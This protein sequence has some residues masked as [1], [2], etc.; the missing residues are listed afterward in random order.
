MKTLWVVGGGHESVYG[1]QRAKA[2]G[3][4]VIVSDGDPTC[5]GVAFADRLVVMS[6]YDAIGTA[7]TARWSIGRVGE[8]AKPPAGVLSFAS[9]V[10]LTVATVADRCGLIG[11]PLPVAQ[12][13]A[14]KWLQ[15][16]A[17]QDAGIPTTTGIVVRSASELRAAKR[18]MWSASGLFVV[19]PVDSRGAR[20]VILLLP[21]VD[22][23]WAWDQAVRYS[24]SGLVLLEEWADG[25]QIST[26]TVLLADGRA[27][28]PGFL[29]RNYDRLQQF[30]PYVIEDGA[31]QPSRLTPMRRKRVI[32]VA[33]AAAKALGFVGIAKGDLVLTADGP[34]VIEMAAR[35]SGG[36]MS[37]V[38]VPAA[39]GVQ[40]VDIAIKLALGEPVTEADVTP[41]KAKACAMRFFFPDPG[42]VVA[43]AQMAA[44][45]TIVAS[46]IPDIGQTIGL[47][48]DHTKRPGYVVA[49]ADSRDGAIR[50][51]E[52]AIRIAAVRTAV[53]PL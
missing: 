12:L 40:L 45:S 20:G 39:T 52:Q 47:I 22:V 31:T 4:R 19:K 44:G 21:D 46:R 17:L 34:R 24:Q 35:L 42:T 11:L 7:A 48:T 16:Q 43:A 10:P 18:A 41:T 14:D 32:E 3:L 15:K 25:P 36:L 49:V 13:A 38:Q 37:S 30:R 1:I 27:W 2:R 26:E 50:A 53:T 5:P 51:A 28:T 33:E 9:D 23:S 29:D 8:S 6:T